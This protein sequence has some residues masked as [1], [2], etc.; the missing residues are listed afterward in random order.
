[1]SE[2]SKNSLKISAKVLCIM[3]II[4][5]VFSVLLQLNGIDCIIE[6]VVMGVFLVFI[7][8]EYTIM[9]IKYRGDKE[10]NK[11]DDDKI[12]NSIKSDINRYIAIRK[13]KV[14]CSDEE[15]VFIDYCDINGYEVKGYVL[16]EQDNSEFKREEIYLQVIEYK[17]EIFKVGSEVIIKNNEYVIKK[18]D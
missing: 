12:R 4:L 14:F 3:L 10:I 17:T 5:I 2:Y 18:A 1:M 6:T 15:L 7:V 13:K 11:T 8:L 9:D 16:I